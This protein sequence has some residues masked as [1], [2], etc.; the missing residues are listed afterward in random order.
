MTDDPFIL[1]AGRLSLQDLERFWRRPARIALD[2]ASYTA[3][4]RSAETVA[5]VVAE[6]RRVYGIN[7]GFG[8]L[9]RQTISAGQVS[10]LQTRL[11]LSHSCGVGQPL[12]ERV[13]RL[14]LLLKINALSRG[15]SGIR[16]SVVDRLIQLLN[17]E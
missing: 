8:S 9:A 1:Q 14:V 7:T 15:H 12:D 5:K 17:E 16:G 11:V 3:L 2:S 6:G 10:E 13:V 4:E